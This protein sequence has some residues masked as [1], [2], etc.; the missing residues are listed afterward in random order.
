[1]CLII[2]SKVAVL[3][4]IIT[5]VVIKIEG[6]KISIKDSAG[7]VYF[8]DKVELIKVD[9][10]QDDLLRYSSMDDKFLRQKKQIKK[11]KKSPFKK[12]KND[13]VLEVDLHV[14]KLVKST[15]GMD[16]FDMLNL[17]VC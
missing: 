2:G 7:M 11:I 15:R 17:Q 9:D 10:A 1:M 3:D 8:F 13:V 16:N 14:E 12:I 6:N 4:D 5:G